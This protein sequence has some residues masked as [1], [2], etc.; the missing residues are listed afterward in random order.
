MILPR[1][2][3]A[4]VTAS[5]GFLAIIS[6]YALVSMNTEMADQQRLTVLHGSA[7]SVEF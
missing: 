7:T 3:T 5:L 2:L 6:I 4:A 1:D